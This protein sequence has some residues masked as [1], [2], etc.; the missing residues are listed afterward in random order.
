MTE[1]IDLY[2]SFR[3]PYCY[4]ALDRIAGLGR[5]F[6]IDVSVRIILPLAIRQPDFFESLPPIRNAYNK[7]DTF[8]VADFHG[9]PFARPEPDPV[10]FEAGTRRPAEQQPYI[11]R[12]SR[13]GVE[14][15]L[16]G[17]GFG[18]VAEVARL[19]WDGK[20]KGWDEGRHLADAAAR[21]GLDLEPL[22]A[23]IAADPA[24]CD[25]ILEQNAQA[26]A[27]AGHWGV[28]TLVVAG[29]PFFGQDRLDL[30]AWRLRQRGIGERQAG[31]G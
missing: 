17:R 6:D 16:R 1:P 13:L 28:P 27:S 30:F 26:L 18:F 8:R 15:C 25:A 14:A 5:C 4:L 24:K 29:E 19:M 23:S 12:I 2:W 31:T 3:S 10:I 9:L 21:A 11:H 20:T 22:E 7:D